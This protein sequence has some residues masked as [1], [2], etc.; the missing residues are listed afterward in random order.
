MAMVHASLRDMAVS[1][2]GARPP[3]AHR[4]QYNRPSKNGSEGG[5]QPVTMLCTTLDKS[6]AIR[7]YLVTMTQASGS[8]GAYA[9]VENECNPLEKEEMEKGEEE[10][11]E[12]EDEEEESPNVDAAAEL[13]SEKNSDWL[14]AVD[15]QDKVVATLASTVMS[16]VNTYNTTQDRLYAP[17]CPST[18]NVLVP[19]VKITCSAKDFR[20]LP[21]APQG[22]QISYCCAQI[23]EVTFNE[24]ER[25]ITGIKDDAARFMKLRL[26]SH[27]TFSEVCDV[28]LR[29]LYHENKPVSVENI[30]TVRVPGFK[31]FPSKHYQLL[32][33]TTSRN[34]GQFAESMTSYE[35]LAEKMST[36]GLMEDSESMFS[37]IEK[38][39][40]RLMGQPHTAELAIK[41]TQNFLLFF[42]NGT[43]KLI[44]ATED[45]DNV[46]RAELAKKS[47]YS[48]A[49]RPL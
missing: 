25:S 22:S 15:N 12:E 21:K 17:F 49:R 27:T 37:L 47:A 3:L 11:D 42:G 24:E 28:A 4:I 35:N 6:D 36:L 38:E 9:L 40:G 48:G 41:L 23:A 46:E 43:Q 39:L 16:T 1:G 26:D 29:V 19:N 44:Q 18:I 5:I 10:E 7:H 32:A 45:E 14:V 34:Q 8:Y 2:Y 31:N 20:G 30:R 33:N 13:L